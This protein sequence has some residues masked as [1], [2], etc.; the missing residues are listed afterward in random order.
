[1]NSSD[2]FL[3]CVCCLLRK[4]VG[5]V[6][7]SVTDLSAKANSSIRNVL[8]VFLCEKVYKMTNATFL[9]DQDDMTLNPNTENLMDF[10]L[11]LF[12]VKLCCHLKKKIISKI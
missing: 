10:C 4:K 3:L 1:M 6:I 9:N 2:S 12:V 11:H 7:S 5:S 8:L